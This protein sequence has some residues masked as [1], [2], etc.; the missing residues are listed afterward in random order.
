MTGRRS[1][2]DGGLTRRAVL[3]GTAATVA[4]LSGCVGATR[5]RVQDCDEASRPEGMRSYPEWPATGQKADVGRYV[6]RYD[7]AYVRNGLGSD[8]VSF[9]MTLGVED[10]RRTETGGWVVELGG[11]Y[12]YTTEEGEHTAGEEEHTA[13]VEEGSVL[14]YGAAYYVD[15]SIVLRAR[16]DG[17][18][19]PPDPID[20][21]D[22]LE[23]SG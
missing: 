21:G 12:H 1:A 11:S 13:V 4:S 9:S 7:R 8:V 22:V 19:D 15:G 14:E 5:R 23:C 6:R 18:G 17:S 10:A 3:A 20:Q 2:F 16:G